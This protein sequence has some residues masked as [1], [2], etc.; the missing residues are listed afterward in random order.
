MFKRTRPILACVG[1]LLALLQMVP[2]YAASV[3]APAPQPVAPEFTGAPEQLGNNFSI[4]ALHI[5][6]DPEDAW[7]LNN[8]PS[9]DKSSFPLSVSFNNHQHSGK[10]AVSGSSTRRFIKKSL[11]ITLSDGKWMGSNKIVLNAMSSDATMMRVWLGWELARAVGMP[12]PETQFVRLYVNNNYAGLYLAMEWVGNDVFARDGYSDKGHL[13]QP[14]DSGF[15]G[16]LS[17]LS[18]TKVSPVSG[19]GCWADLTRG[20]K[21]F[22]P[23]EELVR[24]IDTTPVADFDKFMD[25][26]FAKDTVVDWI[27]VNGL[28]GN[29]D[30]YNKNYFLYLNDADN[31][32]V[33]MPWDFDLSF[34]RN[35]DPFLATPFDILN[36]N[37]VYYNSFD[38][39]A[40]NPLK[41][42]VLNNPALM[43]RVRAKYR[44]LLG[45]GKPMAG[46]PA[47]GWFS[48]E[49]MNARIDKLKSEIEI[50]AKNDPYAAN[51]H[52]AF[53]ED[54]EALKYF[55]LA[56]R[57]YLAT[58]VALDGTWLYFND[59]DWVMPPRK[60]LQMS[61]TANLPQGKS[62]LIMVDRV[63]N[64]LVTAILQNA[65]VSRPAVVTS[66]VDAFQAPSMLPPGM[67][68]EQCMQRSWTLAQF[69]PDA[70]ITTDLLLEFHQENQRFQEQGSRV[71]DLRKLV[72]SVNEN[73][74]WRELPTE[75][76][77]YAK[78]LTVRNITLHPDKTLRFVACEK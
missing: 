55:V 74:V 2:G 76:N 73:G 18:M 22:A 37:F 17:P 59:P 41:T 7:L 75:V 58:N 48:P 49:Q 9:S 35:W 10:I 60:P 54:V 20:N 28:I 51:R 70:A 21:T 14:N 4:D 45:L 26:N 71:K 44:H 16:D 15:C 43:K 69:N 68:A 57:A 3:P 32:W 40:I 31:K 36:D 72:V 30:S 25:A 39:G 27:L 8:K 46:M 63:N 64:G 66:V 53:G 13:Y 1:L 56:R 19:D 12:A 65:E 52:A 61:A 5:A 29:G 50:D 78:T 6:M 67:A 62:S 33:V 23:L 24:K 34:G 77:Y 11:R 47:Y 42:K 38:N